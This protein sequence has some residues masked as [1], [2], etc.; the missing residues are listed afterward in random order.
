MRFI[1]Q[2]KLKLER[3]R[4]SLATGRTI[5]KLLY[6]ILV[7][8]NRGRFAWAVTL[9][10][11][12]RALHLAAF[13]TSIQAIIIA[14][15][16]AS[17]E[18]ADFKAKNI[19]NWLHLPLEY[20]PIIAPIVVAFIF[21]LPALLKKWEMTQLDHI[22]GDIHRA[23]GET[24]MVL[25]TDL[26]TVLRV[27]AYLIF[28]TKFC[29]GLMFVVIALGVVAVFRFDLFL[30]ILLMSIIIAIAVTLS[31]LR[32]INTLKALSP[33][34]NAYVLAA[35]EH[36][37]DVTGQRQLGT[38]DEVPLLQGEVRA[39]L[40]EGTTQN[41]VRV[42]RAPFNQGIFSGIAIG[43]IVWFV[44]GLDDIDE[45]QLVLL[46]FLVIAIRYA[47]NTAR[48]TGAMMTRLLEA[49]TELKDVKI[50][51]ALRRGD[52]PEI[53]VDDVEQD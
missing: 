30:L 9:N 45:S 6:A 51:A 53:P 42:N 34:R 38:V 4:F 21:G 5:L 47:I 35:R 22:V 3:V 16:Y 15:Q 28:A 14:F 20:L 10:F 52:L 29:S 26:F 1:D 11:G 49:R 40:L 7:A 37:R 44:F 32:Q 27:P 33:M 19:L 50:V 48:E 41:W 18:G 17:S 43:A 12:C 36:N 39:T 31:S 13:I 24:S 46:I 23:I 2:S 8:P 25:R